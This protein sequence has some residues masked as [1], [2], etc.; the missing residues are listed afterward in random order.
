[1]LLTSL[2]ACP[3]DAVL[4]ELWREADLV[5]SGPRASPL[6][7]VTHE[8]VLLAFDGPATFRDAMDGYRIVT[9]DFGEALLRGRYGLH[10]CDVYIYREADMV[11]SSCSR[12]GACNEDVLYRGSYY[13]D[14]CSD[15]IITGPN[16]AEIRVGSSLAVIVLPER[17][18]ML[19]IVKSGDVRAAPV[20][21]PA[22]GALGS[23]QRLSPETFWFAS[24]DDRPIAGLAAGMSHPI[25]LVGPVIRDLGLESFVEHVDRRVGVRLD[26]PDVPVV[27]FPQL[28]FDPLPGQP[29]LVDGAALPDLVVSTF[30]VAGT[31]SLGADGRIWVPVIVTITNRGTAV[32]PIFKISGEYRSSL[33]AFDVPFVVPGEGLVWYPFTDEPL[34]AGGAVTF[35]M[36]MSLP[37]SLR[38]LAVELRVVAD[39]CA[40][41]EFMPAYCRVEESD[42]TNNLA[43]LTVRVP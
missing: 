6:R 15:R 21:R 9:D 12:H 39:S 4:I 26:R 35:R 1:M 2:T 19:V 33:G 29:V 42:E 7:A 23:F 31:V 40:G 43:D 37:E 20:V 27:A 28:M 13:Y 3:D 5:E 24:P 34:A 10:A 30:E 18:V 32:A 38:G 11:T 17:Q 16:I 14:V 22:T 25:S 36:E 8:P 41:D